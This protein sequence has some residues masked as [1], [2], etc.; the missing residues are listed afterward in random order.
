MFLTLPIPDK[1]LSPNARPHWAAKARAAKQAR[2]QGHAAVLI[3][4]QAA[5]APPLV[6]HVAW[7]SKSAHPNHRTDDDNMWSSLKN[8]RDGIADGLGVN[9]RDIRQGRMVYGV[10]KARPRVEITVEAQAGE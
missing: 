10:D 1:A 2:H 7:Y 9:D 3:S 4:G 6:M 8:H 5:P